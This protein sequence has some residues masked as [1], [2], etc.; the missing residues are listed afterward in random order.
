MCYYFYSWGP[1]VEVVTVFW[2][3]QRPQKTLEN[4]E[5]PLSPDDLL[6]SGTRKVLEKLELGKKQKRGGYCE[7][8]GK[9][10]VIARPWRRS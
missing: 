9:L 2:E 3:P 6:P 1:G 4:L 10:L 5:N 8:L 7:Q